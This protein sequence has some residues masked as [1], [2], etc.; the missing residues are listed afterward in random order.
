MVELRIGER[1]S[2]RGT[3]FVIVGFSPMSVVPPKA[4]LECPETGE[5]VEANMNE[6]MLEAQFGRRAIGLS[7][8]NA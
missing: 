4:L 8:G 1:I 2:L 5:C 6:L 7:S 3:T